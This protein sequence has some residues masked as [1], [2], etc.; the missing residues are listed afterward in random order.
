MQRGTCRMIP[1]G[2]MEFGKYV[3]LVMMAF[4][5]SILSG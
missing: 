4:P 3:D 1:P 5:M 2:A